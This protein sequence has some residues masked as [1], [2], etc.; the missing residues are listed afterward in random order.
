[1]MDWGKIERK[2]E[3]K[4]I[5]FEIKFLQQQQNQFQ[6][7]NLFFFLSFSELFFS[8]IFLSFFVVVMDYSSK[9]KIGW[10]RT[11]RQRKNEK[12]SNW[13][14]MFVEVVLKLLF[15][16]S[17]IDG[18]FL[19]WFFGPEISLKSFIQCFWTFFASGIL[20]Q[21]YQYLGAPLDAQVDLKITKSDNSWNPWHC[22]MAPSCWEPL[23]K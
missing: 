13:I 17:N 5:L 21:V 12:S 3:K 14:S 7:S 22:L 20:D 11:G 8:L 23:H 16:T 19:S 9:L 15:S 1:M 18:N 10:N 6:I 2:L 4:T